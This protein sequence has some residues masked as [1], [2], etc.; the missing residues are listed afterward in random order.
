[1]PDRYID[2]NEVS[3][4]GGHAAREIKKLAGLSE[5]VDAT[6]L[7]ARVASAVGDVEVE[8]AKARG[9]KNELRD[10]RG[11]TS[12]AEEACADVVT[13]FYHHLR[14]LPRSVDFSFDA[15]YEGQ[16]LGDVA[17]LKPADLRAKAA[18]ILSGFDAPKNKN[19]AAFAAWKS[20]IAAAHDA[21]N[22]ALSGKGSAQNRTYAATAGLVAA[23][24]RFLQVYNGVAKPLVRG[25]L[26][27]V[28]RGGEYRD[29]FRDLTAQESSP[30]KGA[31][32]PQE[33]GTAAPPA[34]GSATP[35]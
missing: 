26:N 30:H 7:A 17:K 1:M 2:D 6:K 31:A 27:D 16:L 23:R 14:S 20:D 25:L 5:L 15:F 13:R 34:Q 8:V 29:F 19:V 32:E 22:D 3:E 9:E 24:E 11:A 10:G 4:Y 35:T 33:N 12:G 18:Y 21:L 28:G